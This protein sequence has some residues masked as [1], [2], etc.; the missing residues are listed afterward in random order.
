MTTFS[1]LRIVWPPSS[2]SSVAVRRKWAKAGYIRSASSTAS[3]TSAGS[4]SS[5]RFCS[6]FSSSARI[7]LQYVALV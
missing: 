7:P 4:S 5:L 1:P 2:A 3:G 6:G